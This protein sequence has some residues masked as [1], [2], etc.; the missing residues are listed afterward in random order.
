[1]LNSLLFFDLKQNINHCV[2]MH[3]INHLNYHVLFRGIY[4]YYVAKDRGVEVRLV[5]FLS[6]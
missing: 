6:S 1:M 3:E 5:K 4:T 2:G